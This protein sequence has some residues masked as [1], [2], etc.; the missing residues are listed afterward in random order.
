[1][2]KF[3]FSLVSTVVFTLTLGFPVHAVALPAD[4]VQSFSVLSDTLA[5]LSFTD[6]FLLSSDK[7]SSYQGAFEFGSFPLSDLWEWDINDYNVRELTSEE[8]DNY[9]NPILGESLFNS[10]GVAITSSD[11]VY[12]VEL[13]NGFFHG[14]AY[15]DSNGDLLYSSSDLGGRYL[16]LGFGGNLL[17]LED[18]KT[19]LDLLI[20]DIYLNEFNLI[21]DPQYNISTSLFYYFGYVDSDSKYLYQV[22]VP[23]AY[24][25]NNV[26]IGKI[27]QNNSIGSIYFNGENRYVKLVYHSGA[28]NDSL[29]QVYNIPSGYTSYNHTYYN[30]VSMSPYQLD[31][32]T[33]STTISDFMNMGFSNRINVY[34]IDY[35]GFR[36][37][38]SGTNLTTYG[39]NIIP[40]SKLNDL[41]GS[42]DLSNYY[43]YDDAI[44]SYDDLVN[45]PTVIDDS[46]D[47][48]LPIGDDNIPVIIDIPDSFDIP[49][50]PLSLPN[51]NKGSQVI[52]DDPSVELDY[53]TITQPTISESIDS[54]QNL[55]V[56]FISGLNTRYPF[57]IPWDI[58]RFIQ[59]FSKEP[60]PPAWNFDWNI[61][62]LNHTYTYHFEGDLSDYNGLAE[63]FR[64]LVLISFIFA[65]CKFSYDHHF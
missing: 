64:N 16:A 24:D 18:Y 27:I 36:P 34:K 54:F 59:R 65:L 52:P 57:S 19:E 7:L 2:R 15:V 9:L 44:S 10:S 11:D 4:T 35:N 32:L 28:D 48:N 3:V 8:L 53:S 42:F 17:D 31:N 13:D 46:F 33:S 56:P 1:M 14:S 38:Y 55:Q 21:S 20:D 37:D 45:F 50:N 6:T 63:I 23:N 22:Y 39:N 58:Q 61:T 30:Q 26:N 62:V 12:L 49:E 60:T 47:P 40:F 29:Y 5:T 43:S 51:V 25:F 41:N